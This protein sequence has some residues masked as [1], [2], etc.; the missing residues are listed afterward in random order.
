MKQKQSPSPHKDRSGN[1]AE[2]GQ[3]FL[4][5]DPTRASL[6]STIKNQTGSEIGNQTQPTQFSWVLCT[7]KTAHK[8][9]NCP[10]EREINLVWQLFIKVCQFG[11]GSTLKVQIISCIRTKNEEGKNVFSM[12]W[13]SSQASVPF[14]ITQPS[15]LHP[16]IPNTIA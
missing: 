11:L 15:G 1:R 13:H 6:F 12:R 14:S 10:F 3:D 4:N 8:V 9:G 2:L 5:L 16:F 7:Q